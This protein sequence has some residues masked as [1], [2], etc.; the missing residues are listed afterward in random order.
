MAGLTSVLDGNMGQQ[1]VLAEG[2]V[3]AKAAFEGLVT[4]MG[5]LVV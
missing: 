5:Q 4:D 2:S 3:R 1:E